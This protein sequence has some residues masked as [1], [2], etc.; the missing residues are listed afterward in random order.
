MGENEEKGRDFWIELLN[1]YDEFIMLGKTDARTIE[2]LEKAGLLR[3]GTLLGQ[4]IMDDFPQ[5][6]FKTVEAFVRRGI[7]DRIVEELRKAPL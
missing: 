7:R 2:L 5:L 3:E 4:K 1:L 6:D